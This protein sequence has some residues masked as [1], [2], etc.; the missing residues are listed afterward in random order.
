MTLSLDALKSEQ[1]LYAENIVTLRNTIAHRYPTSSSKEQADIL[2][3]AMKRILYTNLSSFEES[4]KTSLVQDLLRTALQK[5][6]FSINAHDVIS[7]YTT[8]TDCNEDD[9]T[10]LTQWLNE[11]T[12]KAVSLEEVR[13]TFTVLNPSQVTTALPDLLQDTLGLAEPAVSSSPFPYKKVLLLT[14]SLCVAAST[15]FFVTPVK[16]EPQEVPKALPSPTATASLTFL[17]PE[18]DYLM[19]HLQYKEINEAA[20]KQWLIGRNSLL[21]E[22]PYFEAILEAAVSYNINPLLMFAITGQEQGFVPKSNKKAA[23]IANNPFNVYGSWED[24]NTDIYD[25]SLIAARTIINLSKGCP[26]GEDPIK[27]LNK[28]YAE[29]PNWHKGVSALLKQLEEVAG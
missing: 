12:G 9:L 2:A 4:I 29:D 15:L 18:E 23:I 8:L 21:A 22:A 6:D 1:I 25:T 27:W 26:T 24:F 28:K 19:L 11:T 5:Q 16:P 7:S 17:I 14:G 20:L 10:P 13:A 3:K